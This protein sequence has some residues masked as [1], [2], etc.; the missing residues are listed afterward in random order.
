MRHHSSPRRPRSC[1]RRRLSCFYQQQVLVDVVIFVGND[2]PSSGT[3]LTSSPRVMKEMVSTTEGCLRF[4]CIDF[5]GNT[6][7]IDHCDNTA[8]L[9]PPLIDFSLLQQMSFFSDGKKQRLFFLRFVILQLTRMHSS[10]MRT[11]HNSS[12]LRG[13]G[14]SALGGGA[15]SGGCLPQGGVCSGGYPSMH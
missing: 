11:V 15:W 14:L 2:I 7:C 9:D 4:A 13:G 1:L 8:K 10:R 12:R 5:H 3:L 6:R